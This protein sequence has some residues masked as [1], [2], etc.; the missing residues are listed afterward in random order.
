M[1][2][3]HDIAVPSDARI[4]IIE[5][6]PTHRRLMQSEL[7]RY[8]LEFADTS[9]SALEHLKMDAPYDLVI[10]DQ[11][12][13]ERPGGRATTDEGVRI[14]EVL[15]HEASGRQQVILV[16]SSYVDERVLK[17]AKAAKVKRIFEKP[18]ALNA[19]RD[20]VDSLLQKRPAY[21]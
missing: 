12:L 1:E 17:Q 20:F 3:V 6:D 11:R 14:L 9:A 15:Q 21:R 18:F 16:I 10:V 2:S 7:Q 13:P 19:F 8:S 5:D 4:L